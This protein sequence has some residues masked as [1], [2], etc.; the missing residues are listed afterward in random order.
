M[1]E[2][3]LEGGI[4]DVEFVQEPRTR[5]LL[6]RVKTERGR[7]FFFRG[8]HVRAEF[9]GGVVLDDGELSKTIGL[10]VDADLVVVVEDSKG[11]RGIVVRDD[12]GELRVRPVLRHAFQASNPELVAAVD[13]LVAA[14][15]KKE[16]ELADPASPDGSISGFDAKVDALCR[17]FT[18]GGQ[19]FMT[20]AALVLR[21]ILE[22]FPEGLPRRKE[23]TDES[24]PLMA[25]KRTADG[26]GYIETEHPAFSEPATIRAALILAEAE[27]KDAGKWNAELGL[28]SIDPEPEE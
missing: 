15:P 2:Q 6:G 22:Q 16:I 11:E 27:L 14:A 28:P 1:S 23:P 3:K 5:A 18:E 10:A 7:E 12:E 8:G 13:A 19:L 25:A 9:K 26:K 4:V 17:A 21:A 20:V 24:I